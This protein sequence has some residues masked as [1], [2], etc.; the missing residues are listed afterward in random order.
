MWFYAQ[1]V[2]LSLIYLG[3]LKIFDLEQNKE[4]YNSYSNSMG[5][6]SVAIATN[7]IY[8]GLVFASGSH[9]KIFLNV[10]RC[11]LFRRSFTIFIFDVSFHVT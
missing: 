4:V 8:H 5:I 6:H 10:V 3:M 2:Y 1:N 11:F 7:G 9:F